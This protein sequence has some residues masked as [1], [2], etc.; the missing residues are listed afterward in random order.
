VEFYI[1]FIFHF[2]GNFAPLGSLFCNGQ[3]VSI[4]EY[5][6]AFAL[7]GTTYG[8]D[9]VTTFALP[10]LRGRLP[11]HAG[12]GPGLTPRVLGESGGTERVTLSL[13]QL[14]AH[15]HAASLQLPAATATASRSA[16]GA[17][18]LPGQ[19]EEEL[20]GTTSNASAAASVISLAPFVGGGAPFAIVQPFLALSYCIQMEGIFPSRA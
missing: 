9:G 17:G 1:A 4:A 8:G 12:S 6:A 18:L 2:G 14:P 15:V 10:D 20:Y 16:E 3:L 7:L 13:N 11:M 19:T 5:S